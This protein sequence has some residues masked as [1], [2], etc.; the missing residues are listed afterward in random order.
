VFQRIWSCTIKRGRAQD[1]E[2]FAQEVSLPMF[3]S[4]P[5]FL[6]CL[7]SRTENECD[8]LTLWDTQASIEALGSSRSYN[9]TVEKIRAA[10]FILSEQGVTI[11]P[12]HL[13]A[14]PTTD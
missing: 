8:V 14:F 12:V 4:Q 5:G 7:M 1:Y 11:S 10:G 3:R 9:A 6:A 13:A 2:T